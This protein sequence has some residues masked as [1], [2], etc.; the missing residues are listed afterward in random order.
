MMR[1]FAA[2]ALI[3]LVCAAGA[4]AQI[5]TNVSIGT[6]A[7]V[8]GGGGGNFTLQNH[9]IIYLGSGADQGVT[10]TTTSAFTVHA[11]GDLVILE[12]TDCSGGGILCSPGSNTGHASTITYPGGS[13]SVATGTAFTNVPPPNRT[14]QAEIWHCDNMAASGSVVFTVNFSPAVSYPNV[15]AQDLSGVPTTGLDVGIGN[16]LEQT[17]VT[18][19]SV[20]T[21]G[22]TTQDNQFVVSACLG[23]DASSSLTFNNTSLDV[24]TSNQRGAQYNGTT[25]SVN[26][27]TATCTFSGTQTSTV[28]SV[29]AFAH[30]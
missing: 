23:L 11:T 26:P 1:S 6:V 12:I 15:F 10:T 14:L 24:A 8:G 27:V 29:A 16:V 20:T 30:N 13:C 2:A 3:W 18:T 7:K 17:S 22:N 5:G 9:A 25:L 21:N 28:I 19:A 4:L